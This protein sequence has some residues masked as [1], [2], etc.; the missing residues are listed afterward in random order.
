MSNNKNSEFQPILTAEKGSNNALMKKCLFL[1]INKGE[2]IADVTYGK[3]AFWS[4]IDLSGYDFRPTDIETGT[5]FGNL[6]YADSIIDNLVLDPPYMHGGKTIKKSLNDCYKNRNTS[7]ES[8]IRLYA[9]GILEAA[10]V[11]KKGGFIFVK[12]Q[13]E[14]ESG[15]QRLSH[16]EIIK[17]MEVFGFSIIDLFILQQQSTPLMR[18]KYQKTAR[19]NHSYLVVGKFRR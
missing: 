15:R 13:D 4:G 19:K 8:V 18:E 3:G 5:D 16:I 10:R 11:L 14:T 1:Y 2:I 7:H 9:R 6:D 17:M 12:C